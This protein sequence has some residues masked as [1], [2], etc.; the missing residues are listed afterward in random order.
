MRS[1]CIRCT[2]EAKYRVTF[3]SGAENSLC[4]EHLREQLDEDGGISK[5]EY[6]QPKC[7]VQLC[8]LP[9]RFAFV[10]AGEGYTHKYCTNDAAQKLAQ[11][12]TKVIQI[13]NIGLP[14]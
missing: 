1:T 8:M 6:I 2:K 11:Y 7:D 4:V 12:G 5:A 10:I 3:N 14:E 13:T 9:V